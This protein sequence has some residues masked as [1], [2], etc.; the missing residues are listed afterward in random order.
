MNE[1]DLPPSI[2]ANDPPNLPKGGIVLFQGD[3]I[4]D[5][6]RGRSLDPNHILGHSYAF[7]VAARCAA[8]FPS[9][10]VRFFNRGTSG[11]RIN[12]LHDRRQEDIIQLRPNLL[13]ILIGVNDSIS[14]VKSLAEACS[15]ADFGKQ[16]E[17]LLME[18]LQLLPTVRLVLCEP[19]FVRASARENVEE[20]DTAVKERAAITAAL[21]HR[22]NA[23]FVRFQQTFDTALSTA[24]A[25]YWVWDGIH[26]TYAGHQ[27]MA[28]EWVRSVNASSHKWS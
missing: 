5:G 25:D 1:H 24:P 21:A 9:M 3:S 26:P 11:D 28:D 17:E 13:S 7:L 2:I 10:Q 16:Y 20:M 6:G 8:T 12:R 27:L 23:T 18:V 19:F 15:A 4:T 14:A 22:Y